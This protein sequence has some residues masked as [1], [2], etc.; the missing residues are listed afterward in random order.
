MSLCYMCIHQ[1]DCKEDVSNCSFYQGKNCN[2]CKHEYKAITAEPCFNCN[3]LNN[4]WEACH[5]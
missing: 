5:E 1:N 4:K 2:T 3:Y